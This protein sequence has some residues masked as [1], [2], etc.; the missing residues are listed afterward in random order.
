MSEQSSS[1]IVVMFR[2]L[3]M[4]ACLVAIPLAA[5]FGSALPG[6]F[7]AVQAGRW[8]TGADLR[9]PGPVA[10]GPG[11]NTSGF[12]PAGGPPAVSIPGGPMVASSVQQGAAPGFP[13][14][15]G[16]AYSGASPGPSPVVPARFDSPA[17]TWPV[18]P[19]PAA[20]GGNP[21]GAIGQEYGSSAPRAINPDPSTASGAALLGGGSAQPIGRAGGVEGSTGRSAPRTAPA[22]LAEGAD[23]YKY[24]QDRLRQLGATY[25]LL[26]SWGDSSRQYRFYCR[27]AIGGN[28]KYTRQFWSIDADPLQAMAN[29]LEQVETWRSAQ[30]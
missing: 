16:Q 13:R 19:P 23:P 27:M 3:V 21:G 15:V 8:P 17:D 4:L 22:V 12:V 11:S 6:L 7:K 25:Y 18:S 24:I 5:L 29:V 9:S 1:S 30:P 28:P 20:G 10:Q 26:E 2:A 14:P